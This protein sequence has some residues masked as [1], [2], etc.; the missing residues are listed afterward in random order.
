V[1]PATLVDHAD[2]NT[3]QLFHLNVDVVAQE[4]VER[5]LI[6]QGCPASVEHSGTR[7]D[8]LRTTDLGSTALRGD[9]CAGD[10]PAEPAMDRDS[11]ETDLSVSAAEL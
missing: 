6:W 1:L 7:W 11:H 8:L 2:R 10:I 5:S 9:L 3:S 4:A